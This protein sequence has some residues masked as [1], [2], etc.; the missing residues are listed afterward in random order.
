MKGFGCRVTAAGARAFI[1]NYR[2]NSGRERRY[3]IGAFPDW[4]TAAAR[5]E[6]KRLKGEIRTNGADPVGELK[7]ARNDPTVADLVDRYTKEHLP[8]KR[9][10]SQAEDRGLI[11]QSILPSLSITR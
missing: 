1:L 7:S 6:A 9:P 11:A 2:T 10:G 4:R 3:T 8:K 5:E